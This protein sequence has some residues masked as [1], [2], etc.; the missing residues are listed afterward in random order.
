MC[1]TKD[2]FPERADRHN[3]SSY[4]Y[5]SL[6]QLA[7]DTT[8][9][10]QITAQPKF[11]KVAVRYP[12]RWPSHVNQ[13]FFLIQQRLSSLIYTWRSLMICVFHI[14][15]F[16]SSPAFLRHHT[17]DEM[18][19]QGKVAPTCRLVYK[20]FQKKWCF[21]FGD[22]FGVYTLSQ[23]YLSLPGPIG[24]KTKHILVP[25]CNI[26]LMIPFKPLAYFDRFDGQMCCWSRV[27]RS[28]FFFLHFDDIF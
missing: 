7:A 2:I 27:K 3:R 26:F 14:I 23:L 12:K 28:P 24:R 5:H 13:F 20:I 8:Y 19:P 18:F 21:F 1:P 22:V 25:L 9:L 6:Y 16:L 11:L 15:F 4:Y 17:L 10:V